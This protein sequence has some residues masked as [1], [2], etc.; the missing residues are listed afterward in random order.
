MI[1]RYRGV[2][3]GGQFGDLIVQ[4]FQPGP[5]DLRSNDTDRPQGDGVMSGRDLFGGSTWAFDIATNMRDLTGALS[6]AASL[7]QAWK[8]RAVRLKPNLK[9]PLSYEIDGKW[10]RVYGRPGRFAGPRGDVRAKRGV[11][12]ITADF[13]VMDYRYFDEDEQHVRLDIVPASTG[14]LMAPLIAPLT[15]VASGAARAGFVT[16]YGSEPTPI[17]A[18]FNGPVMDPWVRAAAGWEIGLTGTLA[19]DESVTIDAM[20]G[21]V[22]RS[23][24]APV[25][26]MLTRATKLDAVELPVGQSELSFGGVDL[27]GTASVDLYWRNASVSIGGSSAESA[28]DYGDTVIGPENTLQGEGIWV[29]TGLGDNGSDYT[30]W[31]EDGDGTS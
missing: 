20:T 3:F 21:T 8:D 22:R 23:D 27:T 2:E 28:Y 11:G 12:L 4:D 9:V 16:N 6:V 25:A 29:Q 1:F 30:I 5:F 15:S 31:I 24:G 14:G 26:G 13:R 17:R 7:E 10:R 19:Y 18:T